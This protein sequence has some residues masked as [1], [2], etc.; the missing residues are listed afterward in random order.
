VAG[1]EQFAVDPL[2]SRPLCSV[3]VRVMSAAISV[4]AGGRRVRFG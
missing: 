2:V 4:L 3:A 1:R